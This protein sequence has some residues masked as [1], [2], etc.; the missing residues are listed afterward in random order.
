MNTREIFDEGAT[1][2]QAAAELKCKA[3]RMV[4]CNQPK[5]VH[6]AEY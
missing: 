2:S 6:G 3:D 5:C 1:V 4:W